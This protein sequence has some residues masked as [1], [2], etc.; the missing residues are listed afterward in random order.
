MHWID[1]AKLGPVDMLLSPAS[2]PPALL[3]HLFW[4]TSLTGVLALPGS[5]LV[6]TFGQQDARIARDG[7]VLVHGFPV[8]RPVLVDGYY[9]ASRFRTRA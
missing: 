4:N 7:R 1:D 8:R 3:E 5:N 2:F 6:D 9:T